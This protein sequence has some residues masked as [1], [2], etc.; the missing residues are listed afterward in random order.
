MVYF[1]ARHLLYTS[2]LFSRRASGEFFLPEYLAEAMG[3]VRRE[4]LGVDIVVGMHLAPTPWAD[5]IEAIDRAISS[6]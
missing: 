1:P 2:D 3:A 5:V 6:R 4:G